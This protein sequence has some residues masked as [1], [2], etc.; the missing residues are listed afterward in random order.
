QIHNIPKQT[1]EDVMI[2]AAWEFPVLDIVGRWHPICYFDRSIRAD[3]CFG[4]RSMSSI[5]APVMTFFNENGE[6]KGTFA[7]SEALK[8]VRMRIGVHEE[9]G[10]MKCE[11]HI[12]LGKYDKE[13]YA[14]KIMID[15]RNVP[16][17]KSIAEVGK[18]WE[19]ECGFTPAD[20]PEDAKNPMYSFWYS[21]HQDFSEQEV[22]AECRRAKEMGF[23][24]VILDDGW[25]T[26]DTNRGYGYCGDW[27]VAEKKIKD[28]KKHVQVVHDMGM[29][30]LIWY[31]VPYVGMYSKVWE[32][33][34]DK[35][36]WVDQIQ[37]AGVLDIRYQE[38]REYLSN[39]Y[40]D[41]VKKWDLDG[42]K[43]DFID[44]FYERSTTPLVNEA[45]DC[46]C[47]QEALNKLLEETMKKLKHIK[48]D[49]L[50][51]FRQRYIGPAIRQYGNMLRVCD[52]PNSG[53][54][55]RVGVVDLRLLS[56]S[57]AVHSDPVMWHRDEK[58]E[59]AAL[60]MIACLFA[61]LQFSV[62][63]DTLSEGQKQMVQNYL[64][65]MKEHKDLLQE[66]PI[67]AKEPQNLYPEV[68]VRNEETEI[69]ALYS[70]NRVVMLGD[71][72]EESIIVNGTQ[73][74]NIYVESAQ[75]MEA[76]IT[77]IDCYGKIISK[78]NRLFHGVQS[79]SG[80]VGGRIVIKKR[81]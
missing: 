10:T 41:A 21:Y 62:R 43:L 39:I 64:T 79:I 80:T 76:E 23:R 45:M 72:Q 65:F 29:K 48:P 11:V 57:T 71:G 6:N 49:I 2:I 38:V 66:T 69:I 5:S 61:T 59:I 16:Y 78:T 34:K 7:V 4:E 35:L 46:S 73:V 75:E 24:S 20:V 19:Q 58:P 32:R 30:Y 81:R 36:I 12:N 31:S 70:G 14:F 17:E 60:Q 74:T 1:E 52:C 68:R 26:D 47:L 22:E 27:E 53:L 3:W 54:S 9:N 55:N 40:V 50:I 67:E 37:K 63:L 18:W 51:E 77:I 28:M 56:G 33:F 44:E 8:E 25:Q 15:F 13:E 42:L